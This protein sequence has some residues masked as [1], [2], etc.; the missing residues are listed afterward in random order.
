MLCERACS[1]A[2]QWLRP[3]ARNS[4]SPRRRNPFPFFPWTKP[5]RKR[6]E[7]QFRRPIALCVGKNK[8]SGVLNRIVMPVTNHSVANAYALRHFFK[9]INRDLCRRPPWLVAICF[10]RAHDFDT[11]GRHLTR[12]IHAQEFALLEIERVAVI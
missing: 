2:T 6:L 4:A 11:R 5:V 10:N 8:D 1:T 9:S 3:T 12:I 7:N